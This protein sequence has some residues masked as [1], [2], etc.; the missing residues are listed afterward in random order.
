MSLRFHE[1]AESY[2]KILNPFSDE[3][4]MLVGEICRLKS[5][6]RMLDLACGKGE[7]LARWSLKHG[8]F[9]IGVD[10]SQVFLDA[11]NARA[12]E[13]GV[14]QRI[15]FTKDEAGKYLKETTETN[16]DIVSCIGATWIGDGL[17]GTCELMKP[18]VKPDGLLLIGEPFWQEPPPAAAYEAMGIK[19]DEFI[20]LAGTLDRF[21]S[22]GL[23]LVEMVLA[24]HDGWDRYEAP[25]WQAVDDYLRANP[26]DPEVNELYAW[27]D[28]N[29]RAYLRYGRRYFGWGVFV[30]RLSNPQK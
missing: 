13:V 2:H 11:A 10:I 5:G 22:A 1:I 9:G 12:K 19:E 26:T 25:Q 18:L 14:E 28:K 8:I 23:E 29:R 6:M 20:S 15:T 24:N 21:E 27:M 30:L 4:L 17:L 7:M 3:Q 16:F